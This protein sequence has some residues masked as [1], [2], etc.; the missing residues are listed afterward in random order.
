[1]KILFKQILQRA[2][3]KACIPYLNRLWKCKSSFTGQL[4]RKSLRAN[5]EL[6]CQFRYRNT[7]AA[8]FGS[9]IFVLVSGWKHFY[10]PVFYIG[11]RKND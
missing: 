9:E 2:V 4:S 6:F 5:T 3:R 11:R 7:V 10:H 8:K 1:M